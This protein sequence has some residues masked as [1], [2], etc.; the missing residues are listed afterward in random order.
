MTRAVNVPE[1]FA[2]LFE[3]AEHYVSQLFS[4]FQQKPEKGTLHVGEK[5][6][7]LVRAES[8]Y[9]SLF[10]QLTAAFGEEHAGEFIYNMARIIGRSDSESFSQERGVTDPDAR[11]ST[12]PVHFAYSGWAFVDIYSTSAPAPDETYFLHYHH[13]NTFESEVYKQRGRST[14][15]PVCLFSAGYS[16]GWCSAAYSVEVHGRE[17]QCTARGDP[18]CEFIMAPFDNLDEHARRHYGP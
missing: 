9:V 8:L 13:P 4:E 6:Y 16:A 17:M 7:V 18:R 1:H 5:R 11:L 15:Q 14:T 3:Q 10:D 2:P 12:G